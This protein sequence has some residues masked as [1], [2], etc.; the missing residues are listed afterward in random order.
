MGCYQGNM[1]DILAIPLF[2]RNPQGCPTAWLGIGHETVKA[3]TELGA[4][5]PR[6]LWSTD[7]QR[8]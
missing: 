1:A 8:E 4:Y 3:C 5:P 2:T 6:V 7:K